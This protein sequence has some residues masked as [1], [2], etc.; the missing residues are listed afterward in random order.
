MSTVIAVVGTI[1]GAGTT[2]VATSVGT[3]LGEQRRGVALV[4]ATE[5]GSRIHDSIDVDGDSEVIDAL[6]RGTSVADAQ[7]TGPHDVAVFAADSETNWGAVRP[8]AVATFYEELRERFEFVVVDCG[9]SLSLSRT[10]WLGH[11]D[12]AVIVTDPDVAGAVAEPETLAS[13]FEV[14]VRGVLANRVPHKEVD[15]ALDALAAVGA[16]VLGVLPEDPTVGAAAASGT[17][18]LRAEPDSPIATCVWKLALRIRETDHDEPVVPP[19]AP[20]RT[21]RDDDST[22]DDESMDDE[23]TADG[24][25]DGP[26]TAPSRD[27]RDASQQTE[28]E[29]ASEE[30]AGAS[31][32]DFEG[33]P[34]REEGEE[35]TEEAEE[36]NATERSGD[37]PF[38]APSPA[39][40]GFEAAD[41]QPVE[42]SETE[43]ATSAEPIE[44]DTHDAG[45]TD[46]DACP[47]ADAD[48]DTGPDVDAVSGATDDGGSTGLD[49]GESSDAVSDED[50]GEGLAGDSNEGPDP[51]D[52]SAELSDDE[53]ETVFQETMQRVQERRERD[54]DDGSNGQ[55]EGKSDE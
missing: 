17:S 8:D 3:A 41:P 13:A 33:A 35:E 40:A 52:E 36:T 10:A 21:D 24:D 34:A 37:E 51:V 46:T 28:V 31:D 26:T 47:D 14:P 48:A 5:E 9:C 20:M 39:E 1:A 53:I 50:S 22:A 18:V 44:D 11:A 6:R 16:P 7:A 12:E 27:E 23:S 54:S 32:D 55:S 29:A 15:S 19:A 25:A 2:T 4:D 30:A 42:Q 38:A 49:V 45:G 43:D